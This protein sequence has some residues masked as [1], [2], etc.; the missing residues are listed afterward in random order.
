MIMRS[1][2]AHKGGLLFSGLNL[3]SRVS[4]APGCFHLQLLSRVCLSFVSEL[5]NAVCICKS[6]LI[7]TVQTAVHEHKHPG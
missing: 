5:H 2:S 1:F 6:C 4:T 3:K 7:H